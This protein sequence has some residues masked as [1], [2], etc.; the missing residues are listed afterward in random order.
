MVMTTRSTKVVF[1]EEAFEKK[2][3][4]HGSKPRKNTTSILRGN[5]PGLETTEQPKK[6]VSWR[7]VISVA[8]NAKG[9][10]PE[11][12]P[13]VAINAKGKLPK[14]APLRSA[15]ERASNRSRGKDFKGATASAQPTKRTEKSRPPSENEGPVGRRRNTTKLQSLI[16]TVDR[17]AH[18]ITTLY[19]IQKKSQDEQIKRSRMKREPRRGVSMP[20]EKASSYVWRKVKPI[21]TVTARKTTPV[22]VNSRARRSEKRAAEREAAF[23]RFQKTG[24]VVEDTPSVQSTDQNVTPGVVTERATT[25]ATPEMAMTTVDE[26]HYNAAPFD[27][28]HDRRIAAETAIVAE[29]NAVTTTTEEIMSMVSELTENVRLWSRRRTA[30]LLIGVPVKEQFDFTANRLDADFRTFR[31]RF[32]HPDAEAFAAFVAENDLL[33]KELSPFTASLVQVAL[34]YTGSR[35]ELRRV[36]SAAIRRHV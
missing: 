13:S 12:R 24:S 9:K 21:P 10:T 5:A 34:R 20:A 30:E 18:A 32:E 19:A 1:T 8:I 23:Q 28:A 35:M 6:S 26:P 25:A 16:D 3:R 11:A 27:Y 15:E 4:K 33:E 22:T 14:D 2:P 17:L 31:E 29:V 36:I 7:P